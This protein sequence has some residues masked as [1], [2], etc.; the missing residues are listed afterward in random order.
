MHT[1]NSLLQGLESRFISGDPDTVI[2]TVVY[3]SRQA[4]EGSLFV[5]IRGFVTD[6]HRFIEKVIGLNASAILIEDGQDAYPE[7]ELAE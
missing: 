3:D 5:C 7:S 4:T 1:L 6:G 2:K